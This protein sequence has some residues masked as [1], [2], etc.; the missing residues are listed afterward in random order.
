MSSIEPKTAFKVVN[1]GEGPKLSTAQLNF[2]KL[3]EQTNLERVAKLEKIRRR[4]TFTGWGLAAVV[5]GI[6]GYSMY[7]IKQEKF[8]DDFEEP[9][10]VFDTKE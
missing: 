4:N 8:L 2:M 3:I 9:A 1:P 7:A 10:K 5:V 6:Y